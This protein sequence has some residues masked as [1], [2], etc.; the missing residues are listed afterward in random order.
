MLRLA[1]RVCLVALALGNMSAARAEPRLNVL[2]TFSILGDLVQ[3]VGGDEVAV[4]VLVG[5]NGDAH[6]F[7]PSPADVGRV[8]D[9]KLVFVNGL[10]LEGWMPRL[11]QASGSKAPLVIVSTGIQPIRDED[12]EH[13]GLDPHA[14]QSVANVRIYIGTIRD[15]LIAADPEGRGAYEAHAQAYLSALDA[16]ETDVRATIE[17]I[18]P[19]NRRIITTHDAFGYFARAYGMTFIAPQGVSTEAE[20]SSRDVARIIRQIRASNVP[21]VFLE[22]ISDTRLIEQIARETRARIGEKVYSDSLSERGGPAATYTDMIRHNTR[23]FAAALG[24]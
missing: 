22:N 17:K 12:P 3:Q 24:G 16:L 1:A 4:S 10:G 20:A 13:G 6:V 2:A 14:W 15:A 21:A 18:P 9:A 8:R 19:A 11:V 5:P 7:Q 23:A